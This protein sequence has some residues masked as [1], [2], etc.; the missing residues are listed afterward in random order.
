[1]S[2]TINEGLVLLASLRE[3]Y[4][5]LVRL[6]GQNARKQTHYYG[7]KP[8]VEEPTYDVKA[9]DKKI[10]RLAMEIRKLDARIKATNALAP[11]QGYQEPGED[12][13]EGPSR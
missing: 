1:M 5:E 6:Q 2:I 9:L 4:H 13:F 10:S 3:R 8:V 11:I 12:I 7:E